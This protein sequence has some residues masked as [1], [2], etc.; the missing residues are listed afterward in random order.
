MN[1]ISRFVKKKERTEKKIKKYIPNFLSQTVFLHQTD[2][3]NNIYNII[4]Y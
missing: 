4:N 3:I 2:V 1:H